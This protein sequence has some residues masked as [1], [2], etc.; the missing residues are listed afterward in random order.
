MEDREEPG[1]PKV[2]PPWWIRLWDLLVD[3]SRVGSFGMAVYE[4][5]NS[6]VDASRAVLA[7]Q[8]AS[9][10]VRAVMELLA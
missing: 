7:A 8:L 6:D 4:F 1:V 9:A 3:V 10:A 2:T 5:S